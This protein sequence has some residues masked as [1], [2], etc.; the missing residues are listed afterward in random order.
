MN[1]APAR[2]RT[3]ACPFDSV[4]L[5]SAVARVRGLAVGA[6]LV[7]SSGCS[8]PALDATPEGAVRV[9]LDAMEAAGDDPSSMQ[10]VYDLLG[11]DARANLAERARRTSQLQGRQVDPS[12]MLAAGLFGVAFR[13]KAT[14]AT[15]V[16]DRATVDVFGED[17]KSEHASV[18]CVREARG[19]RIEPGLPNP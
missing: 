6:V 5:G 2:G 17:P 7:L 1:R 8:H 11:P 10:R 18:L 9:F 16:G 3:C 13:P 19:W 12:T 15:I 14:R 4:K